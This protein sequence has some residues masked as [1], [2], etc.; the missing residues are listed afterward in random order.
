VIVFIIA[1][2]EFLFFEFEFLRNLTKSSQVFAFI[3]S[4]RNKK[5]KRKKKKKIFTKKKNNKDFQS[6]SAKAF[7][8]T[9]SPFWFIA[10][11]SILLFPISGFSLLS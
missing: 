11:I 10:T 2:F 5:D 1:Y 9:S 3:K 8:K 7:F 6:I 4:K